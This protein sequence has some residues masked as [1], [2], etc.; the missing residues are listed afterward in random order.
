MELG[1]E[2][3]SSV[4][5]LERCVQAGA[6]AGK[7]FWGRLPITFTLIFLAVEKHKGLEDSSS[8]GWSE[9]VSLEAMESSTCS[10][11]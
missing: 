2:L 9:C 11:V 1:L 6:S 10:P 4:S 5:V 3:S 8:D 7:W